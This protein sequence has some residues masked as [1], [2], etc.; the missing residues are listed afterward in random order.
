MTWHAVDDRVRGGSSQSYLT[1]ADNGSSNG[2]AI[3]SGT[4]DTQTLGGAGFASQ[5]TIVKSNSTSSD[6]DD[7]EAAT[8]DLED[9]DGLRVVVGKG[10]TKKYTL[11]LKDEIPGKREDGRE[12]SGVSWESVFDGP[13][14]KGERME[15]AG[16][17]VW[18]P[19]SGFEAT[20]RG[21]PKEDPEP[22]KK[23]CIRQFGL[24]MRR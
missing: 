18:M 2:S 14:G 7:S 6:E 24:M 11:T 20:Y 16:K 4:L 5:S 10:D 21:R 1:S 19:W 8:W 15:E 9:Y 22:L 12:K 23:G 17:E 13:G 3:F